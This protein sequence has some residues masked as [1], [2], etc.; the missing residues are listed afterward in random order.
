MSTT[1]ELTHYVAARADRLAAR[2]ADVGADAIIVASPANRRY[3]TGFDGSFG[4]VVV[5]ASGA[6]LFFTDWRYVEQASQQALGYE[7]VRLEKNKD[8]WTPLRGRLGALNVKRLAFEG[9]LAT[10]SWLQ[11]GKA[12]LDDVAWVAAPRLVEGLRDVK[13]E[14]EIA[15]LREAQ[16]IADAIWSRIVPRVAPGV[17]ERS[18]AIEM[19][20]QIEL[21]GAE[22][23]PGIPIVASGWRAA[24]PHGRATDK[25][26]ARGEFVLF[27]FGAIVDG[28]HSDMTR[29]VC[30]GKPDA[31]QR[32][33]YDI[34]RGCMEAGIAQMR[35]GVTGQAVDRASRVP[36]H[37]AGYGQYEHGFSVGHGL[38]LEV[39]EDPFL[40][41][42]YTAPLRA[43]MVVT[44]EPGIYVPGWSGVRVEDTVLV[45]PTG[46]EVL[47]TSSRELL[48]V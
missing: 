9:H 16:V 26:I 37:A 28:Y 20:H 11:E 24:L 48:E 3:L 36:I 5:A 47:N 21:M 43:G 2:L 31:K 40:S 13:D 14:F 34:V 6:R 41:D 27:D 45:T 23:Y 38:G 15:R 33:V 32:E 35:E 19:R 8:L 17:T 25:V 22:N 4:F 7:V 12:G 29:M 46:G 44:V 18:L 10:H 42:A 30:V 1:S 39:H